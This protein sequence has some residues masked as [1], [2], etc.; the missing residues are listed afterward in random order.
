MFTLP[1]FTQLGSPKENVVEASI[2]ELECLCEALLHYHLISHRVDH[3]SMFNLMGIGRDG[4][5]IIHMGVRSLYSHRL[6]A[7]DT[8]HRACTATS[9]RLLSGSK[10]GTL[11]CRN[12]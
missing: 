2:R 9:Q 4:V 8:F 6:S 1:Q 11:S 3:A 5:F 12:K 7:F 10:P